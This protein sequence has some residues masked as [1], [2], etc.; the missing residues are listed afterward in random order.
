M[1]KKILIVEDNP[2]NMRLIEMALSAESY[3]ILEATT[4]EEALEIA[5]KELPDLIIMDI[6]L[7]QMSGLEATR[8]LREIP[9]FNR[10]PII[11]ITAYA[12]QEDEKKALDAG[13]NAYLTKP[14][15]VRELPELIAK[16][17]LQ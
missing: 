12:M 6:Q 11:A 13:C 7:P 17:L 9:E 14:I 15:R 5:P 16:M 10:T 2:Q 4:G 3:I 1:S 8:K